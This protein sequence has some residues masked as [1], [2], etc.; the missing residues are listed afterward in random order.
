MK[1]IDIIGCFHR[2]EKEVVPYIFNGYFYI[3]LFSQRDCF[4][5]FLNSSFPAIII[6]DSITNTS[7]N[8]KYC[9]SPIGFGI[10]KTY[11]QSRNTLFAHFG[12][13]I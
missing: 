12:I 5:Y 10:F 2:A 11:F 1:L 9:I 4:F 6:T 3:Q 7:G 13:G 8:K